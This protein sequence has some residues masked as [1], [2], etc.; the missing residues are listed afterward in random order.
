MIQHERMNKATKHVSNRHAVKAAKAAEAA[1][2][3]KQNQVN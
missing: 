1:K 2:A 3:T